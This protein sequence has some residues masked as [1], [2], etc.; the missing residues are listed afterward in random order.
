MCFSYSLKT[1]ALLH[2]SFEMIVSNI[3][4][5]DAEGD[6]HFV[7]AFQHAHAQF[8]ESEHDW[9]GG[10]LTASPAPSLLPTSSGSLGP[11][12]WL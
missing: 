7:L 6:F 9:V 3:L 8:T 12:P 4:H 1:S 2:S 10:D 5:V 11:H